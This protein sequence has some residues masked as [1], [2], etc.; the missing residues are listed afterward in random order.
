M[1][2]KLIILFVALGVSAVS[3]AQVS[4]RG[5]TSFS[6]TPVAAFSAQ[7][8]PAIGIKTNLIYWG[9]IVPQVTPNG[10]IEF[11]VSNKMTINFT[12][13]YNPWNLNSDPDGDNNKKLVH[14]AIVPEIKYWLCERF[15]GSAVGVHG[16]YS[17][18]NVAEYN[19]PLLFEKEYRYEGTTFGG[20]VSYNYHYMAGKS[21]GIEFTFGVGFLMMQYDKYECPR[22]GAWDGKYSK[23][24]IGPTKI[25]INLIYLIK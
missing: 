21:F 20:G 8:P 13:S 4:N 5:N 3:N 12:G 1:T 15:N 6:D 7:T 9:S 18:Y 22:C 2:K 10:G 17:K 25:G 11:G 24:Y 19:I 23:T 14:F 16:I